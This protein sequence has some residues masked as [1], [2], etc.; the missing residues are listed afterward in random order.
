MHLHYVQTYRKLNI[1]EKNQIH[2]CALYS[3]FLTKC[4][5]RFPC[6]IPTCQRCFSYSTVPNYGDVCASRHEPIKRI[7]HRLLSSSESLSIRNFPSGLEGVF[8]IRNGRFTE[9]DLITPGGRIQRSSTHE[10]LIIVWW[11]I[12]SRTCSYLG[13]PF[14]RYVDAY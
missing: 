8:N 9:H 10:N 12:K 13:A 5:H 2:A 6:C 7:A 3:I 14:G 1:W 11:K 4:C